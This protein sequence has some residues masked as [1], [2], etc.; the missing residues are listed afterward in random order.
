MD[1]II[2]K[3]Q[4]SSKETE[5]NPSHFSQICFSVYLCIKQKKPLCKHVCVCLFSKANTDR[6]EHLLY[7]N[8]QASISSPE[9]IDISSYS[10]TSFPFY[11][12]LAVISS[13]LS[14]E[15]CVFLAVI[16]AVIGL[17]SSYFCIGLLRQGR[18]RC[19]QKT[20]TL[21]FS[22]T[23]I[24]ASSGSAV[25]ITFCN[26]CDFFS[27]RPSPLSPLLSSCSSHL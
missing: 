14:A 4:A 16:V 5:K 12:E 18:S 9:I 25:C 19:L 6:T 8:Y 26:P 11:L 21:N 2:N 17:F 27:S 15:M 10:F 13:I 23:E 3:S 20:K 1:K 24:S 7:S 22:G